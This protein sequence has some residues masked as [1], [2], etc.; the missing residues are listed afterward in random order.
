MPF[1]ESVKAASAAAL[2]MV[3]LLGANSAMAVTLGAP[4]SATTNPPIMFSAEALAAGTGVYTID[5][6][7]DLT[8]TTALGAL[9]AVINRSNDI[10]V[11]V[12]VGGVL[13]LSGAPGAGTILID[14]D[15]YSDQKPDR[16]GLERSD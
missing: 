15:D 11:R 3:A 8:G 7:T 13:R 1:K 16:A 5:H 2:W 9:A 10:Y 12:D 6:A 14:G 4:Q